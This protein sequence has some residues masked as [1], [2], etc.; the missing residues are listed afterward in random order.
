MDKEEEISAKLINVHNENELGVTCVSFKWNSSKETMNAIRINYCNK[1]DLRF[2]VLK[3]VSVN[4]VVEHEHELASMK[5]ILGD[6]EVNQRNLCVGIE[7]VK[8]KNKKSGARERIDK[9]K[10]WN[11]MRLYRRKIIR[12]KCC[13]E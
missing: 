10:S 12:E 8:G 9:D 2:E 6:V 13:V 5:K 3:G 4:D 7:Q 1:E 11:C